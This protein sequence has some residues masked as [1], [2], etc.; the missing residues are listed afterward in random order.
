[1]ELLSI[2]RPTLLPKAQRGDVSVP[3]TLFGGTVIKTI[4]DFARG[5]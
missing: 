4:E 1:M 3:L 2:A 5:R